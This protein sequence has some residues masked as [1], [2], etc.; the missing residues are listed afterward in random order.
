MEENM[1]YEEEMQ[2]EEERRVDRP[3]PPIAPEG[4]APVFPGPDAN[5]PVPPIAPEGGQPVD[6]GFTFPN[7][8]W[9][10][11]P[12]TPIAPEGGRPVAPGP[13]PSF[14]GPIRPNRPGTCQVRFLNAAT[15]NLP[16]NISIGNRM[17]ASNL[18][19]GNISSYETISDGFRPVTIVS[20]VGPRMVFYNQTL[21]F[22]A[23]EKITMVVI[24]SSN[25]LDLV[26]V[27]DLGCQNM[28]RNTGCFRMA[29]M[30]YNNSAYDLMLYGGDVV[31]TDVR[32]KEVTPF[33]QARP[34]EYEFY[35]TN[36]ARYGNVLREIPVIII[37]NARPPY[38]S[39]EPLLS[40]V[41][42]INAGE[43]YTAY[44]IGNTWSAFNL[45][46]VMVQN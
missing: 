44:V 8:P 11:I 18:R 9:E 37:T 31:F 45:R 14:P 41:T 29:N 7:N 42:T 19:F 38:N 21:P 16:L 10:N 35:M 46:V 15:N 17:A 34:G 22:V 4:G 13:F 20:A 27:S 25:G 1:N 39:G 43:M 6:P 23:G 28:P 32:F 40:F 5:I 33:K 30:S 36:T 3:V 2:N 12:E 26:R 24:D